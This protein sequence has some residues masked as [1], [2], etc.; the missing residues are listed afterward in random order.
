MVRFYPFFPP[1]SSIQRE[2]VFSK[3]KINPNMEISQE[4]YYGPPDESEANPDADH[5]EFEEPLPSQ[6]NLLT[7]CLHEGDDHAVEFLIRQGANVNLVNENGATPVFYA[8]NAK[9]LEILLKAGANPN[10]TDGQGMTPLMVNA[11]KGRFGVEQI[12]VLLKYK[13]DK[14]LLDKHGKSA[15]DYCTD[16]KAKGLLA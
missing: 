9:V 8:D 1:P 15:L 16:N 12:K 13:A 11:K 6:M 5:Y 2:Y 7:L 4:E 3:L 10:A 14:A